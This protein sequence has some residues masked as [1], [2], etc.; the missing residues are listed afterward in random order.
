MLRSILI[1]LLSFLLISSFSTIF[2]PIIAKASQIYIFPQKRPI[3]IYNYDES[4]SSIYDVILKEG[5]KNI[6]SL[7][8][9]KIKKGENFYKFLQRV[10]YKESQITKILQSLSFH[11][12]AN[13]IFRKMSVG[14]LVKYTLPSR[15]LGIGIEFNFQKD[16]DV[17][18]WQD[19]EDQFKSK[20]TKR[21]T[22]KEVAFDYGIIK[23]NLYNS[24]KVSN[25]P[26]TAFYE[27]V[28]ILGF[29]VDFQRD[30]RVGDKFQIFYSKKRDMIEN[31]VI[32]TEP[33]K[34]VGIE[35]SGNE[36]NY[37]RYTTKS[38]YTSYFDEKG[39]SS[40]KTL[41]KTPL[42][43]ARLSSGYGNRKHPILG[44]NKFHKGLD[45]AAPKGT[46]VFAAGDGI[47]EEARW[48]GTYGKYVRIRHNANYKTAYAHLSRIIRKVN[49]KVLQGEVIGHVG[50][51]GRSTGPHLHYEVLFLG[52]RVNPMKIKLPSGKNIPKSEMQNF[53]KHVAHLTEEIYQIKKLLKKNNSFA[54]SNFPIN[55][56]QFN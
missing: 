18:V 22:K 19:Y 4:L 42:N 21:P 26:E 29:V 41:M 16:K 14:H 43:G 6:G 35:L 52:K 51:T 11:R 36:L 38:G 8:K 13:Q 48:N 37:Y 56:K 32:G 31:K 10:G 55:N 5:G 23:T 46:P 28:K 7:R 25:T 40:K 2:S 47:I 15:N 49:S 50:N 44:Y 34:F 3:N 27:M 53:K 20:I 30:L 24:S 1:F 33:L 45:F 9:A 54:L 39:F 12:K 17:Y